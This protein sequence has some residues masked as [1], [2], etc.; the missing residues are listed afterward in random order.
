MTWKMMRVFKCS[1]CGKEEHVKGDVLP[2][3]WAGNKD[4]NGDCYCH[5]CRLALERHAKG[6]FLPLDG[7]L[8]R[9]VCTNCG[10]SFVVNEHSIDGFT[11]PGQCPKC[12]I[13]VK[14]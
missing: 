9:A 3:G 10:Y 11:L 14:L 6:R 5:G 1:L 4:E 2:A 8:D 12:N 7:S 13:S